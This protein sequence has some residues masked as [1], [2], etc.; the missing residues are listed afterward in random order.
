MQSKLANI[1]VISCVALNVAA[2][3]RTPGSRAVTGGLMGA[4][5]GAALGSGL[6]A[7]TGAL[8]GGGAGAAGGA[9]TASRR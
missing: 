8:M 1:V 3:G 2:C 7:G 6:G 5:G 4:G 9:L